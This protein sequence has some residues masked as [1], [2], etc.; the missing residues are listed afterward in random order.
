MYRLILIVLYKIKIEMPLYSLRKI[1]NYNKS[2]K[3]FLYKGQS[4]NN[5]MCLFNAVSISSVRILIYF[6]VVF[7]SLC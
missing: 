4:H 2:P 3:I 6:C 1:L 5:C 7:K